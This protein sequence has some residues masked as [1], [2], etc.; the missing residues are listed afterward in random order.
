MI[1]HTEQKT[2]TQFS[3]VK[4]TMTRVRQAMMTVALFIVK[5]AD[6]IIMKYYYM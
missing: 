6:S 2:W 3:L 5:E 1:E 4:Y